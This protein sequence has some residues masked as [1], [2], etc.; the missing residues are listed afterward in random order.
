MPLQWHLV[1]L[2]LAA[3]LPLVLL[4]SAL[5][6]SALNTDTANRQQAMVGVA[7]AVALAVDSE[8]ERSITALQILSQADSVTRSDVQSFRRR[9]QAAMDVQKTWAR[10]LLIAPD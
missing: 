1:R 9:A 8:L 4:A 2:V 10:V 6:W 5:V 7:R 3:L